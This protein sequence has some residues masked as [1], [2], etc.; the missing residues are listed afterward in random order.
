[1]EKLITD[2][3][4]EIKRRGMNVYAVTEI[5][6]GRSESA[7]LKD[8]SNCRDIYSVSKVF[9]MSAIGFLYDEERLLPDETVA[10]IF[11]SLP[12]GSDE[13]WRDVTV[14][15]ILRHETGLSHEVGV[16]CEDMLSVGTDDW[17]S[18]IFSQALD[19]VRGETYTYSDATYYLLS[20]IVSK[21]TNVS[22]CDYLRVKLFC[23]LHFKEFAWSVCPWG[24]SAG[25][26]GL[27][28]SCDDMAKLGQLWLQNGMWDGKC[29]LSE[30]WVKL[31]LDNAYT[32]SQRNPKLRSYYK[33]GMK[34]QM[35]YFS[36]AENL[37]L[38][39]ESFVPSSE[40]SSLIADLL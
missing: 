3:T 24:Y 6:N 31:S 19:G 23:P 1:M 22:L 21:K 16:E 4:N 34:G 36:Y 13:R 28:I 27:Y 30:E 25:G 18:Y 14:H 35:L 10:D 32:F 8:E 37:V 11:G 12:K 39:I 9:T 5:L 2:M 29:I 7:R 38:A 33:T 26:S 20:R 15:N 40:M 17:L